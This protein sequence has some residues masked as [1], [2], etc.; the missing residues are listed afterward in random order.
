[1]DPRRILMPASSELPELDDLMPTID[2][3]DVKKARGAVSLR[4]FTVGALRHN[5]LWMEAL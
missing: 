1:L 5:L 3:V 4:E 2:V